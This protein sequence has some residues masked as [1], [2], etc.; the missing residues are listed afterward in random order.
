MICKPVRFYYKRNIFVFFSSLLTINIS[1]DETLGYF[2][3]H[4]HMS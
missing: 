2:I 3:N 1:L 4:S